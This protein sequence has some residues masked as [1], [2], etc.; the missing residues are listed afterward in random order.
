M[1]IAALSLSSALLA[2]GVARLLRFGAMTLETFPVAPDT[3]TVLGYRVKATDARWRG[4]DFNSAEL[5]KT[6]TAMAY[7]L[8]SAAPFDLHLNV[9]FC[10]PG[11]QAAAYE[12][13]K[14]RVRPQ[15]KVGKFWQGC[16]VRSVAIVHAPDL[17]PPWALEIG[18]KP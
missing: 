1:T 17:D 7:F 4:L 13:I 10:Y 3:V 6:A 12:G 8:G 14:Y 5:R 9:P 18:F 2:I 11:E 15:A 16:M